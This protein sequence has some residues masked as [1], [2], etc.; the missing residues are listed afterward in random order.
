MLRVQVPRHLR[1]RASLQIASVRVPA[2]AFVL[3]AALTVAGGLAIVVGADIMST[4]ERTAVAILVTLGLSEL[5]CWGRSTGAVGRILLRHFCR[6][7]RLWLARPL[8]IL[9]YQVPAAP[10]QQRPRWQSDSDWGVL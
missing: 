3:A 6:P 1:V 2:R 7:R 8:V 9:P 10:A 5:R 4:I